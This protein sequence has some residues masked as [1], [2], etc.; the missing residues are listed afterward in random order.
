MTRSPLK[1]KLAKIFQPLLNKSIDFALPPL[2]PLCRV[3]LQ[4]PN[5][6]CGACWQDIAFITPPLCRRTGVPM[7]LDMGADTISLAALL[8]P[9]PY[10]RA[11]AAFRYQDS[12]ARLVRRFKF[13][14]HTEIAE[15]LAMLMVR[16]SSESSANS[17]RSETSSNFWHSSAWLVP[18]PLHRR[19]LFWRRFNQ[20]AELCRAL[21][22]HIPT[23]TTH[24][25]PR[26]TPLFDALLRVR[27]TRQQVG[28]TRT[29]RQRN[30][31]G[32][33]RVSEKAQSHI[34][35]ARIILVDDVVTTGATI[36]ACTHALLQAGA[37]QVDVL[38]A[39]RVVLPASI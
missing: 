30:L 3:P 16:A 27:A 9:P 8:R 22:R 6:L 33:F 25:I 34:R 4:T 5:G 20:A 7:P 2:C 29:R 35:G 14:D 28:L 26:F 13:Y 32:A 21:P 39:A 37:A 12:G 24:D 31:R 19:R 36:E 1:V 15:I 11:R 18:V 23:Y 10:A 17:E 38:T